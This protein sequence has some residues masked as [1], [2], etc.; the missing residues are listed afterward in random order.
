MKLDPKGLGLT[1]GVL[2]GAW[3]LLA[4]GVSLLTGFGMRTLSTFGSWHPWFSYSWGG[5]VWMVVLHFVCGY[6]AGWVFAW[7]YNKFAK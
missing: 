1:V 7:V 5:L 2:A 4:M 3:W 6:V